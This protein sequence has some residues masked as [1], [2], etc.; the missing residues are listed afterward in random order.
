MSAVW[1]GVDSVDGVVGVVPRPFY[2][3]LL[4]LFWLSFVAWER[5]LLYNS[6]TLDPP[7][8]LVLWK[9]FSVSFVGRRLVGVVWCFFVPLFAAVHLPLWRLRRHVSLDSL[10]KKININIKFEPR[11]GRT[12]LNQYV[13]SSTCKAT[14]KSTRAS[15]ATNFGIG[16]L[17]VWL[18]VNLA[19]N[20]NRKYLSKST[21][22]STMKATRKLTFEIIFK[23]SNSIWNSTAKTTGKLTWSFNPMDEGLDYEVDYE[24]DLEVD[25][26]DC[27]YELKVDLKFNC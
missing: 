15:M 27:F 17:K 10:A 16:C 18:P 26:W 22:M 20:S 25:L 13:A 12:T 1:E 3:F 21:L 24:V 2:S 11:R 4:L 7:L 19:G 23:N 14:R 6:A 5:Y 8:C 9:S